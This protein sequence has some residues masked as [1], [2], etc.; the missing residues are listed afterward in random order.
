MTSKLISIFRMRAFCVA[1]LGVL[2]VLWSGCYGGPVNPPSEEVTDDVSFSQQIQPIFDQHC[3]DCHVVGGF[4][5]N[6]VTLQLTEGVSRAMLVG[7]A[8]SQDAAQTLVVAGD[9]STSLLFLKVSSDNPPVGSTMPL[10]GGRL[11]SEELGLVRDWI[12]QGA[13]DN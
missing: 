4:A 11:S 13:L 9:S 1:V 10:T 6:T 8:S 7:Q 2:T 3:I 5:L 12:D